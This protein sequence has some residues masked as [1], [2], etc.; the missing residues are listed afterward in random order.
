MW[1]SRS[2]ASADPPGC[3]QILRSSPKSSSVEGSDRH[4]DIFCAVLLNK[5]PFDLGAEIHFFL[6]SF[7]ISQ[8]TGLQGEVEEIL[9]NNFFQV[10]LID[11]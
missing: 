10:A 6:R 3:Q 5:T 2:T 9:K 7:H 11:Y 8:L 4:N 1:P